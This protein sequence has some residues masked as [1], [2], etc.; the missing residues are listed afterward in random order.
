MQNETCKKV[1][2]PHTDP[3]RR[4][5]TNDRASSVAAARGTNASEYLSAAARTSASDAR[6]CTDASLR[7]ELDRHMIEYG[8]T[9]VHVL[10]LLAC[11]CSRLVTYD[12]IDARGTR[13]FHVT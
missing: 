9:L 1:C 6:A 3:S 12:G 7:G 8:C 13:P 2:R 11:M 10:H 5:G 4:A